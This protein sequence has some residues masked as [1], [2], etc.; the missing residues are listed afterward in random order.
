MCRDC[1]LATKDHS[2][3]NY[4][5][6]SEMKEK[7]QEK[8]MDTASTIK[9][10]SP[11][12]AKS[13]CEISQVESDIDGCETKCQQDIDEAFGA[14][15]NTLRKSEQAMKEKVARQMNTARVGFVEKKKELLSVQSEIEAAVGQAR[16]S[17]Q[18]D[19]MEFLM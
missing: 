16:D 19:D 7:L 13:L 4:G 8:L 15:Y 9:G 2:D 12:L 10:Q 11:H 6:V 5:F 3:H 18:E 1:V 14:L 17:L